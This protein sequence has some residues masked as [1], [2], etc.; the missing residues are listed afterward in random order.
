MAICL[1]SFKFEQKYFIENLQTVSPSSY[2]FGNTSP[3]D[4]GG[5]DNVASA[6]IELKLHFRVVK[7]SSGYPNLFQTGPVNSGIRMEFL[8][9]TVNLLIPDKSL[10]GGLKGILISANIN[11]G[12]WYTLDIDALNGSHVDIYLNGKKIAKYK[13]SGINFSIAKIIIGQGFDSTRKFEGD[14]K[15]I[16]VIFGKKT[17]N[18]KTNIFAI[19]NFSALLATAILFWLSSLVAKK[20]NLNIKLMGLW[21]SILPVALI[22]GFIIT[23]YFPITEGWFSVFSHLIQNGRVPYRDFYLYVTPLYPLGLAA[24]QSIFGE[25]FILLRILGLVVSVLTTG[26]LYLVLARIFS[27]TSACLIAIMTSIYI[28]SG[29]AYI[30]YDFLYFFQLF[31]LISLYLL[32]IFLDKQVDSSIN[33]K[34]LFLTLFFSGSFL[35]LAF[36]TKQSNGALVGFFGCIAAVVAVFHKSSQY[37]IRNLLIFIFGALTP[38]FLIGIWLYYAGAMKPFIDQVLFGAIASKGE[39]ITKILFGWVG[40]NASKETIIQILIMA[41]TICLS[42]DYINAKAPALKRFLGSKFSVKQG[43]S[44]VKIYFW[45][46]CFCGAIILLIGQN[47]YFIKLALFLVPWYSDYK[48]F[49]QLSLLA[50]LFFIISTL[51][52]LFKSHKFDIPLAI[53]FL[54]GIGILFGNGT[55]AD[56]SEAGTFLII[57]VSLGY[58]AN[59]SKISW[60]TTPI[61]GVIC[62]SFTMALT[63]KKFESP[64]HWWSVPTPS[65]WSSTSQSSLPLLRGM[66]LSPQSIKLIEEVVKAIQD[67]SS[68]SDEV[69]TFPHIPLFNLLSERWPNSKVLVA[70]FDILPDNLAIAEADRIKLSPP[71]VIVNLRLA[72]FVWRE[73]ERAFRK[74]V[75]GQR[76]IESTIQSLINELGYKLAY[77]NYLDGGEGDDLPRIEVWYR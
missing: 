53:I 34:A 50:C 60:I 67:H 73:H 2:I 10:P 1:T 58:V 45:A 27:I 5:N 69:L 35:S 29:N 6:F 51:Y 59:L 38:F 9:N 54:F 57:A 18:T 36:L 62:L 49:I 21:C 25:E 41:L 33:S 66:N 40:R 17:E 63:I 12:E 7:D 68:P 42:L 43:I 64:Y 74:G 71:K 30:G 19:F 47:K 15:D 77:S 24:F 39:S 56:I 72:E 46:F 26:F 11:L 37:S 44:N 4:I 52:S 13:S 20:F 22:N 28:Q 76:Q 31:V 65:I 23:R 16:S 3:I 75:M 32:L 55:S 70:W 14:I 61:V 48:F 8:N